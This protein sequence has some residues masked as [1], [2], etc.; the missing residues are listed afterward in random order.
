MQIV[1]LGIDI[2]EVEHFKGLLDASHGSLSRSFTSG[3]LTAVGEKNDRAQHLAGRFAAKEA[4]MKA[5]GTGWT[6]DI[7][8]TDIEIETLPSGAPSVSLYGNA[9]EAAAAAGISSWLV[10]ISH[11]AAFAVASALAVADDAQP[12]RASG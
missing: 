1:G 5:L 2:V 8:L 9:A 7:A 10:S 3:E 6:N 11:T 4:V 12:R